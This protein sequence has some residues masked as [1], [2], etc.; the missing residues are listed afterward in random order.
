M[1][2]SSHPHNN[3]NNNSNN[4]SNNNNNSTACSH[5]VADSIGSKDSTHIGAHA[6]LDGSNDLDN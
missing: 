6:N 2:G 5:N 1:N 3:N 4:N